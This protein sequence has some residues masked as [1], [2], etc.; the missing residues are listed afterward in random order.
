MLA[1]STYATKSYLYAWPQFL[2]RITAAASHHH[3]AHFIFATDSS[4]ESK[5]ALDLAKQELPE[6]WMVTCLELDIDDTEVGEKYKINSQILIAKL[7]SIA[8]NFARKI[9]A[10]MLWS[11]ESDVL[12]PADALRVSEWVLKMPQADGSPYYDVAACT[13]PNG[14]FLGGFG[15]PFSP[16]NE[17]FTE[18]ERKLP[19]KF[20]KIINLC[21]ERIEKIEKELSELAKSED[22][23][24]LKN[25]SH[26]HQILEKEYKR[27]FKL[28]DKLKKY[29][30]DGNIWDVTAKYG[31]KRRGWLDHAYPGIGKGSIVPSDWCGLGCTLMSQKALALADFSGYEGL[32]TQDLFLCWHR[33]Y[34][35]D[36]KISIIP[37]VA[38]D[39]VKHNTEE[40]INNNEENIPF[41]HYRASHATEGEFK[42][43]LR[44]SVQKWIPI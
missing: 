38:C 15:T 2:K 39:H 25:F 18:E 3:N 36:I 10:K 19:E 9:R 43:H 42:N 17:D 30:P 11:V 37:H 21:N 29:P 20:K 1:I 7:Q 34:P 26:F 41:I 22:K 14:M 13:Y 27:K 12:V 24:K 32:G 6:G 4:K 35:A 33:W 44:Q 31:W 40:N 16:I 5:E 28:K 8:F 23:E